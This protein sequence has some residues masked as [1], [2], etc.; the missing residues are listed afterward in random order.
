LAERGLKKAWQRPGT[1]TADY[2]LIKEQLIPQ[3]EQHEVLKSLPRQ[4]CI[5]IRHQRDNANIGG[6]QL[7]WGAGD[8]P[9]LRLLVEF[10]N[11]I[12]DTQPTQVAVIEPLFFDPEQGFLGHLLAKA[13]TP[14]EFKLLSQPSHCVLV[15]DAEQNRYHSNVGLEQLKPYFFA[16]DALQVNALTASQ[17][18]AIV[19]LHALKAQPLSHLRWFAAFSASQGKVIK[20]YHKGDI[21]HLNRWP[22][23]NLPGCKALIRLAAFMQSNAVDLDTVQAKTAIPIN[24]VYDFYNAC[25]VTQL[26]VHS[27]SSEV[28]EKQLD[29]T[30]KQLFARIGKRLSQAA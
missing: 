15:V 20:G 18:P 23:V 8:V 30:Q 26:I 1:M 17:L 4:R 29:S 14:R 6:H 22:D 12:N 16:T 9:S 11:Q 25:K 21:V 13:D 3:M 5:F 24:Q 28:H 27:Q 7:Y 2:F 19:A 10:L